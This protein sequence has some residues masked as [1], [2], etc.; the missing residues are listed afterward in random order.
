MSKSFMQPLI[1]KLD[2]EDWS[3]HPLQVT[4]LMLIQ[5]N[6]SHT[7]TSGLVTANCWSPILSTFNCGISGP[8][9]LTS[10]PIVSQVAGLQKS[11]MT[12]D[13]GNAIELNQACYPL[14]TLTISNKL[15][16][17]I[18]MHHTLLQ[19]RLQSGLML[20]NRNSWFISLHLTLFPI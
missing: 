19:P 20:P 8:L 16:E 15:V 12:P 6:T 4:Y 3:F 17:S 2:G 5:G 7:A 18:S 14:A 1:F 11:A 10:N 13:C 9:I